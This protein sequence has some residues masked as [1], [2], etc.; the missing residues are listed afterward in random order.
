MVLFSYLLSARHVLTNNLHFIVPLVA[1]FTKFDGQIINEYAN[2]LDVEIEDKWGKA[3]ENA[4]TTF[5]TVYL[6]K[7]LNVQHPP[8]AYVR[9]EG[10]SNKRSFSK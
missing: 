9:L 10:Q 6:P 1:V 5:Q 7:V 3:R 4:E 2:L 8:K